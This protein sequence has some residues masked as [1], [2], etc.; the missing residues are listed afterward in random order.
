MHVLYI[1]VHNRAS[2]II[3]C[4]LH[5]PNMLKEVDLVLVERMSSLWKQLSIKLLSFVKTNCMTLYGLKTGHK[6]RSLVN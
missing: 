6:C 5:K 2:F 3:Q 1:K 4:R